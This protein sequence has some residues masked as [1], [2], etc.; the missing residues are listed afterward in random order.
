MSLQYHKKVLKSNGNIFD[1]L[2]IGIAVISISIVVFSSF[3]MM[4]LMI[5]KLEVSQIARKYI[6]VM[7]TKGC[8]LEQ[9]KES[10]VEELEQTGL[11]DINIS[12]TTI[13]PVGYGES[14]VLHIRGNVDGQQLNEDNIWTKAFKRNDY[15][16]EE[17]RM[18]TAKN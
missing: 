16:V 5:T 17:K 14:I 1:F 6:L 11:T 7:E 8:L 4:G 3:H 12:G 10:M 13:M 2:T 15:E 18:S 9:D